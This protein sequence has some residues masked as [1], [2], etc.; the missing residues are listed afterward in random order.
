MYYERET[1]IMVNQVVNEFYTRFPFKVDAL[2]QDVSFQ[3]KIAATFFQNL[4]PDVREFLVSEGVRVPPTPPTE[5]N[6]QGN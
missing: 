2:P 4:S 3:L 6:Y 5:K 1:R